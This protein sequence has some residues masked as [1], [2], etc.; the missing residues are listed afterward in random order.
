MLVVGVVVVSTAATTTTAFFEGL[1]ILFRLWDYIEISLV[2]APSLTKMGVAVVVL[3]V[4]VARIE[5]IS[6]A[7]TTTPLFKSLGIFI[8]IGQFSLESTAAATLLKR[9]VAIVVLAIAAVVVE[10]VATTTSTTT[11]PFFKRF[12][13]FIGIC[14]VSLVVTATL[15][16]R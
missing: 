15:A 14:N 4:A 8:D 16:I 5:G 6:T 2:A 11:A 10:V 9:D 3:V 7:T 13:I 1:D 12:D